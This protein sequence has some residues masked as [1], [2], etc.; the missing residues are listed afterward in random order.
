ML[1]PLEVEI[2]IHYYCSNKDFRNIDAPA[3]DSAI[4]GF[5]ELGLLKRID[6]RHLGDPRYEGN[7]NALKVYVD[8]ICSVPLPELKWTVID[9]KTK[10]WS[11]E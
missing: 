10:Q 9:E 8:A 7:N 2:L 11:R 6:N 3:V 5:V 4:L 1:S